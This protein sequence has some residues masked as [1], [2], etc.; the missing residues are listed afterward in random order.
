GQG[1]SVGQMTGIDAVERLDSEIRRG[2]KIVLLHYGMNPSA[3]RASVVR[4]HALGVATIGELGASTYYE[5]QDAGVDIFVHTSRYSLE[6]TPPALRA[7]VAQRP[8]GPPR[9][10]YYR[11]LTSLSP[12]DTRPGRH[13]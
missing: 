6:I 13:A 7:R 10:E 1:D 4:A 3:L 5:A 8:F 9:L 11:Y 2:A 12:D